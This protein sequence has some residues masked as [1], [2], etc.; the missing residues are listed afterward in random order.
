MFRQN[1]VN[2]N[3]FWV[4]PVTR[5]AD[6]RIMLSLIVP[7]TREKQI[8][9]KSQKCWKT[10]CR[11]SRHLEVYTVASYS[12]IIHTQSS[13]FDYHVW[14]NTQHRRNV[15]LPVVT[16]GNVNSSEKLN[17]SNLTPRDSQQVHSVIHVKRCKFKSN[18]VF[19]STLYVNLT[20]KFLNSRSVWTHL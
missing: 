16:Q 10:S 9:N 2:V 18:R 5:R 7:L 8:Q 12:S 15:S 6:H 14:F 17:I 20:H 19:A 4:M 13:Y 11:G 1:P 3:Y